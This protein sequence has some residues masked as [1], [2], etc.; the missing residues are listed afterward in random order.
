MKK[1]ESLR[2]FSARSGVR[3]CG[4][5]S[6]RLLAKGTKGQSDDKIHIDINELLPVR[7]LISRKFDIKTSDDFTKSRS[8]K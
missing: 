2:R 7:N 3:R 5:A 6:G 8:S 4:V 1:R